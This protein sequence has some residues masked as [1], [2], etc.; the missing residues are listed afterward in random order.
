MSN[1]TCLK[2]HLLYAC[3]QA[4]HPHVPGYSSAPARWLAPPLEIGGAGIDFALV[5]RF[6]EGVVIAFRGTLPPL[7]LT[8]DGKQILGPSFAAWPAIIRDWLNN[9][10]AVLRPDAPAPPR[11]QLPGEIHPGFAGSLDRLWPGIVAAV[12]SLRGGDPTIR[13]YLTGHSKGGALA[14]LGAVCARRTWPQAAV[15]VATFGAARAGDGVFAQA[16][17]AEGIDCQRYEVVGDLVPDI[18]PAGTAIGTGHAVDPVTFQPPATRLLN[19]WR[20]LAPDVRGILPPPIAAHLPY[21]DFGY[22]RHV[23]EDGSRPEWS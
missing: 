3:V 17:Q 7:D 22:D 23:Y 2:R 19:L 10:N 1:Q 13:L 9:L 15:K 8:P 11:P 5:G 12:D 16:Y 20:A 6:A 4:Y 21:H 18:P 14:N